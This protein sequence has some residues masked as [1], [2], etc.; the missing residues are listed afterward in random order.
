MSGNKRAMTDHG[1][2]QAADPSSLTVKSQFFAPPSE[3][4]GCFTSFYHLEVTGDADVTLT[5][6]LQPEWGNIRFFSGSRPAAQIGASA[7]ADC[8]FN[9]TGP[10]SLPCR[11]ELGPARM[12]G[13]GLMPL[14]WARL[15]GSPAQ[16]L[17]NTVADGEAHPAFAK[18]ARLMPALCSDEPSMEE[19]YEAIVQCM[20][21]LDRQCR[22]E[23]KIKR[24]HVA[25]VDGAHSRVRDL[26]EASAMSVRTLERLCEKYFGFSPKLLMRRQRFMRSL[27]QF[28]LHGE[29]YWTSAI[30]D[31]YYDQAQFSR[32]FAEFM[33]MSPSEYAALDHPFLTSFMEARARMWGS[34]AQTLDKPGR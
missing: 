1:S 33:T 24:V 11:F 26:A 21:A 23:A 27:T 6:Y 16:A 3:F 12:W 10:S 30:D 8:A 2:A 29:G 4:E 17:V 9:A 7:V 32:E 13:I 15:I 22:D 19:Q 25:L 20:R 14:G 5:D 18:F 31:D 34:A 28:M